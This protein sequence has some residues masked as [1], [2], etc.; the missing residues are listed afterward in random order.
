M[1]GPMLAEHIG[2]TYRQL[3][4]WCRQGLLS[5]RN[6]G[7]GRGVRR[8]FSPAEVAV[9]VR[10]GRLVRAG[11]APTV[12]AKIARGDQVAGTALLSALLPPGAVV[13]VPSGAVGSGVLGK[14]VWTPEGD[15]EVAS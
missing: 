2:V 11:V 14:Q 6:P 3:D 1:N 5:P 4:F 9:A 10:M 12:A 15:L 7:E 13:S 8:D